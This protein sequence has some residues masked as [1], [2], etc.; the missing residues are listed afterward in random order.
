MKWKPTDE[1]DTNDIALDLLQALDPEGKPGKML[2]PKPID[3]V[4]QWIRH[5]IHR[6][7]TRNCPPPF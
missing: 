1:K 6:W 3:R 5:R 4:K 2:R 7:K